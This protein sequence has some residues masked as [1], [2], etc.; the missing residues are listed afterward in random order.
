MS[1]EIDIAEGS[2]SGFELKKLS[3]KHKQVCALLA[4]GLGRE[5]IASLVGFTPEYITMLTTQP[6]CQEYIRQMNAAAEMQLTAMF[7]QS[8][9]VISS[10][11]QNGN[12]TEQLKGA[13]LQLEATHRIGRVDPPIASGVSSEDRLDRLAHRLVDLLEST[14]PLNNYFAEKDITEPSPQLGLF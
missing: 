7:S 11:M 1:T 14:K 5:T 8:V 13:R 9:D 2:T 3:Q 10:A 6:L 12:V 4:Q